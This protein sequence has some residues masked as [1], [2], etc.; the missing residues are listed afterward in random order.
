LDRRLGGPQKQSGRY[1]ER[2]I[3][4]P[5]LDSN[6]T[7]LV[8]QPVASGYTVCAIPA[9]NVLSGAEIKQL[10]FLNWG[11]GSTLLHRLYSQDK[12][13]CYLSEK[14]P[15]GPQ[16]QSGYGDAEKQSFPHRTYV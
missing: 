12:S 4:D 3:L 8:V 14:E 1:E 6:S 16:N 2:K 10:E 7:L 13:P 15:D 9:P 5:Y 11:W